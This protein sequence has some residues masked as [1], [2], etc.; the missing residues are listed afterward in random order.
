M[1]SE[2]T[3]IAAPDGVNV[4]LHI[5]RPDGDA[6]PRGVAVLVHGLA[7]HSARYA[8]FAESLTGAGFAVY[9]HDHRGH[10]RT[11]PEEEHGFFAEVNGWQRVIDDLGRVVARARQDNPGVP[12]ALIGH[13]MG[14][15]VSL[16][17]LLDHSGQIDA[18]VLSGPT[19]KVGPLLKIGGVVARLEA[20]RIGKRG[21]SKLLNNMAFGAY[22]KAFKPNR[23][24]FDWLSKDPAEVDK[25]VADPWCGFIPTAQLWVDLLGA[26]ALVQGPALARIRRDLPFYVVAGTRDPVGG[27]GAQVK[28]WIDYAKRQGLHVEHRFWT[29]GRHELFNEVEREAAIADVLGWLERTLFGDA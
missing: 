7:E 22:N 2:I 26:T 5:W 13:S 11:S 20:R 9:A 24:E 25:Y 17:W 10:G 14:T 27:D 21:R 28:A 18:V 3:A 12:V 16:S 6:T 23:T 8:R 4:H 15:I 19:G 29:D 1:Q